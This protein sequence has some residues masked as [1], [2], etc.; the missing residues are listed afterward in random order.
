MYPCSVTHLH[1]LN[2]HKLN[3]GFRKTLR[4]EEE[5]N[6]N[7]PPLDSH[8]RSTAYPL[9]VVLVLLVLVVA[10]VVAVTMKGWR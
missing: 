5:G 8:R 6:S 7:K 3:T 9:P 4:E 10:V 2:T 1:K